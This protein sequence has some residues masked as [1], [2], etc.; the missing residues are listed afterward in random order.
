MACLCHRPS[1]DLEK[2]RA[3][4]AK[5]VSV[6]VIADSFSMELVE[7]EQILRRTSKERLW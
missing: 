4:G 3:L 1:C 7:V 6:K 5:G 2:V